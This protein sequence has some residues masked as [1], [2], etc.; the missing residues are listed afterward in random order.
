MSYSNRFV[1]NDPLSVGECKNETCYKPTSKELKYH[2][3]TDDCWVS[4]NGIVYNIS[5]Y[6]KDLKDLWKRKAN[7]KRIMEIRSNPSITSQETEK[8]T[9]KYNNRI[10]YINKYKLGL[11]CGK[12]YEN[13]NEKNIFHKDLDYQN[14]S[15]GILKY[16]KLFKLLKVL[17]NFLVLI[18]IYYILLNKMDNSYIKTYVLIPLVLYMLYNIYQFID[19]YMNRLIKMS[20][21]ENEIDNTKNISSVTTFSITAVKIREILTEI[22]QRLLFIV[23]LTLLIVFIII[24]GMYSN[25]GNLYILITIIGIVLLYIFYDIMKKKLNKDQPRRWKPPVS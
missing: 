16:Y 14:Y 7:E 6:N 4:I 1:T 17:L 9:E 18:A 19:I 10:E 22:E 20:K 13:R 21:I 3:R 25:I 8:I 5:K 23:L 15:I 2:T 24:Y 12:K 11:T